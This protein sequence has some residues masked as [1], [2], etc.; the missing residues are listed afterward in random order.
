MIILYFCFFL[1]SG[2]DPVK[3]KFM[4]VIDLSLVKDEK[5]EPV[6]VR[7]FTYKIFDKR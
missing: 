7:D 5:G 6:T 3:P 4:T 2:E 1:S